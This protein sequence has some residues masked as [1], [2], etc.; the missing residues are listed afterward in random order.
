[1]TFE[2]DDWFPDEIKMNEKQDQ[3]ASVLILINKIA[4]ARNPL[5]PPKTKTSHDEKS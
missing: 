3:M 1:M 5:S 2:G 4:K